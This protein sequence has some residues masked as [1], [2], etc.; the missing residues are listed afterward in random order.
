MGH[1]L[2]FC[3]SARRLMGN[4]RFTRPDLAIATPRLILRV[5]READVPDLV[6]GLNDLRVTTMLGMVTHPYRRADAQDYLARVRASAA[7]GEGVHAVIERNGR[8][9]GGMSIN[10]IPG[11]CR[12]GYWLARPVWGHG[13]ATEAG[14]ALLAYGFDELGLRLIRSGVYVD[15]RASMRVQHKL[16]FRPIGR[17]DSL[18]LARGV[19]VT[20]IDTV[21]T[22]R[23]FKA[24]PR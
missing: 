19:T 14:R 23:R 20:H 21:L 22:R 7:A 4:T 3:L 9:I 12:F 13:Y 24:L 6:A 5:P 11:R 2:P 10:A 8:V 1:H 15:N 17:R 18:S 16:G